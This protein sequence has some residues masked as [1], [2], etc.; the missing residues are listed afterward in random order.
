ME[1]DVGSCT[2]GIAVDQV[3]GVRKEGDE[4][5]V[6]GNRRPIGFPISRRAIAVAGDERR[7]TGRR[8]VNK[9][10]RPAVEVVIDQV[11]G[12]GIEGDLLPVGRERRFG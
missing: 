12:I 2:I 10:V 4:L 5:A 6:T 1:K 9:D 3:V 7:I 8:I 11:V